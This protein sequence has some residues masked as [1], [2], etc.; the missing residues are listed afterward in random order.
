MYLGA[1]QP[2]GIRMQAWS[3]PFVAN[4]CPMS[5]KVAQFLDSCEQVFPALGRHLV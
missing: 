4:A 3:G 5:A 1:C 2:I